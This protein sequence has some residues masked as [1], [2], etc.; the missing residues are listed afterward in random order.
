MN[1]QPRIEADSRTFYF[2]LLPIFY[3]LKSLRSLRSVEKKLRDAS[4]NRHVNATIVEIELKCGFHMIVTTIAE[5]FC[6]DHSDHIL[7]AFIVF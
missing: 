6:S 3:S 1:L 4:D 5:Y 7:K 2:M